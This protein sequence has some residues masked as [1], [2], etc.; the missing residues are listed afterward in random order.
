AT[1]K[2][3]WPWS[4]SEQALYGVTADRGEYRFLDAHLP[5]TGTGADP[6]DVSSDV[7]ALSPD[8][9]LLAYAA[10][11]PEDAEANDA[12]TL[13]VQNLLTG[14]QTTVGSSLIG[15]SRV[16]RIAWSP[17][18]TRV[19]I[20]RRERGD[21]LALAVIDVAAEVAGDVDGSEYVVPDTT[22]LSS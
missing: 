7:A 15:S 2:G 16:T 6:S 19:E 3:F 10:E 22:L 21:D 14:Q 1:H 9:T 4:A 13:V 12:E 18:G 20:A 11:P 5:A 17:D 8:G